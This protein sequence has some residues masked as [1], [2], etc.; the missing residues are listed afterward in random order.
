MT[1]RNARRRPRNWPSITGSDSER[2]SRALGRLEDITRLIAEWVWECDTDGRLTFV[3]ERIF[4]RLGL[5]PQAAVGRRFVDLGAFRSADGKPV[6]PRWDSPFRDVEFEANDAQGHRRLFLVSG[7]PFFNR[8]TWAFEGASGT[9]RDVTDIRQ[10]ETAKREFIAVVSHELRTPLTSIR[11]ALELLNSGVAGPLPEKARKMMDIAT[12]NGDRLVS[13]IN[14]I[15]DIERLELGNMTFTIEPVDAAA[16]LERALEDIRA[17]A[18]SHGVA[19]QMIER[20]D[21]A[22]VDADPGRLLQVLDNLLS[23]AIKFS[24]GDRPVSVGVRRTQDLVRLF[25]TDHGPGIPKASRDTIF[26]K[27]T[28]GDSSSTRSAGGTGLGL[29]IAKAIMERLGGNVWFDTGD[30]AGT[31]FFVD[32]PPAAD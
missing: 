13:L 12:R 11:G 26:N 9:A 3:S 22:R 8:D 31:T 6:E 10:A 23:N 15:L 25:V 21:G 32:L 24:P 7:I 14:D 16:L 18:D 28:Q 27:F 2:A 30:G 20:L 5:V 4:E 19:L 29:A 17:F 1:D